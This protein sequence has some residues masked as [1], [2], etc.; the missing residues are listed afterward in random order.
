MAIESAYRAREVMVKMP[1]HQRAS[2]L[3]KL[4][5]LLEER[6]EEAARITDTKD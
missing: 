1:D 3:E 5:S 2:I 4:S 6:S